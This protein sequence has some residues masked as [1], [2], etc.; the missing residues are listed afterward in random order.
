M[1]AFVSLLGVFVAVCVGG[2]VLGLCACLL[3]TNATLLVAGQPALPMQNG[4]P[5]VYLLASCAVSAAISCLFL[6]N[7][8]IRHPKNALVHALSL[9]FTTLL[10][11]GAVIP[12][13][14]HSAGILAERTGGRAE[15]LPSR[16]Y[17]RPDSDGIFFYS[18][19]FPET[20]TGDGL[21]IDLSGFTGTRSGVLRM[22]QAPIN[23]T[24]AE[25]FSDL[26]V[27]D[28]LGTPEI[29]RPLFPLL[30]Q[31]GTYA[32]N[33]LKGGW[34][35]WLMFASIG[36]ALMSLLGLRR[37]FRWR[38]L[39]C[40]A[41]LTGF[42]GILAVN[43]AYF[44]GWSGQVSAGISIPMWLMNCIICAVLACLGIILAVLR[45]DPNMEHD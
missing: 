30:G 11:W 32:A 43:A 35:S 37:L 5:L 9:V 42:C 12:C 8:T 3:H 27:R 38:L 6:V 31:A 1:K 7:H 4:L 34:K 16:R 18:T 2:A 40:T 15:P 22:E 44:S 28:T 45:A 25:P 10:A 17:F 41:V 21:Y 24:A 14:L 36:A 26:L 39:N 13:C 23:R 33:A 29:I 19:V 20:S